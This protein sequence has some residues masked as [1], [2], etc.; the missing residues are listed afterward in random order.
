MQLA[1]LDDFLH[2]FGKIGGRD[3]SGCYAQHNACHEEKGTEFF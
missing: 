2:V 1:A 3:I